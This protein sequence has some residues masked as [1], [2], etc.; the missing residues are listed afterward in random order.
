MKFFLNVEPCSTF[1]HTTGVTNMIM[2]CIVTDY[3]SIIMLLLIQSQAG[4]VCDKFR[5]TTG[6]T[7]N[8]PP[9]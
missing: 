7:G 9:P 5:V 4:A 1:N 8:F 6:V 3:G 2:I